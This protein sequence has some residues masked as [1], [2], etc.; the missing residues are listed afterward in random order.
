MKFLSNLTDLVG[1]ASLI[2]FTSIIILIS[3]LSQ[4]ALIYYYEPNKII[5]ISEVFL[6]S[7]GVIIG[8]RRMMDCLQVEEHPQEAQSTIN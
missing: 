4:G 5:W 2:G 3:I 1:L 6:G 7:Y 8:F